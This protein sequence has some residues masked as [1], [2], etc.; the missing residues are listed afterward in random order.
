MISRVEEKII[1][2]K[3]DEKIISFSINPVVSI[4]NYL[5]IGLWTGLW[6]DM[7]MDLWVN[8]CVDL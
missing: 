3:K 4:T 6:V 1:T 7:S 8:L 2:L 5:R